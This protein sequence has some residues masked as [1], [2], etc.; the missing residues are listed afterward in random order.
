MKTLLTISALTFIAASGLNW[1]WGVAVVFVWFFI[2]L[3]QFFF[4]PQKP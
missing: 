4:T 1:I 2:E 3:V